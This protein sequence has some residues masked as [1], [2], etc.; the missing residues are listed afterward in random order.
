[1]RIRSCPVSK[2]FNYQGVFLSIL[3][4]AAYIAGKD[5]KVKPVATI[6][7]PIMAIAMGPQN[8]LLDRGIIAST[9][10]AAA[11]ISRAMSCLSPLI[12]D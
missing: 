5:N 6:K 8:T 2:S 3:N 7:P 4:Q 9:A 11:A 1:M 10:A 12:K